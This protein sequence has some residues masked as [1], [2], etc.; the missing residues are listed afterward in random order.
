[1]ISILFI[2]VYLSYLLSYPPSLGVG[3]L[4]TLFRH[5]NAVHYYEGSD[6]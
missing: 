3:L 1:M 6:S 4:S 2:N 5:I